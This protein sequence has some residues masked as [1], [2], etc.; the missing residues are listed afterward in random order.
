MKKY[1]LAFVVIAL[2]V[3]VALSYYGKSFGRTDDG[4]QSLAA[5]EGDYIRQVMTENPAQSRTI[6]WQS[7]MSEEEPVVEY[8]LA[9]SDAIYTVRA[10]N[11]EFKEDN[12]TTYVHTAFI[13]GLEAGKTYEYRVGY[14]NKRSQWMSLKTPAGDTFSALIF[15]DSQ[16]SDYGVWKTTAQAAWK[17][18]PKADFFINMGDLVDN[19]EDMTQWNAWF[20]AITNMTDE[21]PVAP[22]MGNHEDYSLDWKMR[23]PIAYKHLFDLPKLRSPYEQ[24]QGQFYSYDYGDVHFVVL[25]TQQV[26]LD[27]FQPNLTNDQIEWFKEDMAKNTKKWTVVL[28]HKDPLQYAFGPNSGRSGREEGFSPEGKIWMPLFDEYH[29]DVVL[30][31]HLHTYR[32]RGHIKNFTRSDDGPL[33]ILTGVAG[34]NYFDNLWAK[35]SLDVYMADQ[36][37]RDN[38]I[39]MEASADTLSFTSYN[40]QGD[41]MHVSSV[42]K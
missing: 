39:L 27:A 17:D 29:V 5:N 18:H 13:D 38:Y 8:R 25:D 19:G 23:M 40:V 37:D 22:M 35:H 15:P 9:S 42:T 14:G 6:M 24:Y 10:S 4:F 3:V 34:N 26:E 16:S 32:D 7:T 21:I 33:Y 20:N 1:W 28:M 30:S 41:V 12:R 36:P 31:A 11:T 2:A